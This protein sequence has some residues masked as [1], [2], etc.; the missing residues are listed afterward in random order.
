VLRLVPRSQP[1]G[2][3]KDEREAGLVD[4]ARSGDRDAQQQLLLEQL[5]RVRRLV[6]RLLGGGPD[7]DDVVQVACVETLKSLRRFRGDASF[8]L[9]TDRVTTNV[10]YKHFRSNRRRRARIALVEDP[11]R[12]PDTLDSTRRM[13]MR[14][15]IEHA[16][17]IVE[18][19]KPERRVVF[20]LVAVD[21]RTVEEAAAMLDLSLSAAKSRYL[22]ARRDIDAMLADRPELAA[23]FSS[24]GRDEEVVDG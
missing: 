22:R 18:Q 21:G 20:L 7:V 12:A 10:V 8:A 14:N 3:P 24:R 23:A 17:A 5:P 6:T 13:E 16:R 19:V 4:R 11:D 15:V 2:A 9:W 1:P